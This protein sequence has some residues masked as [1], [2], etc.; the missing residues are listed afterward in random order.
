[1]SRIAFKKALHRSIFFPHL[2]VA[3]IISKHA[4]QRIKQRCGIKSKQKR[5][6]FVKKASKLCISEGQIPNVPE[7]AQFK[8]YMR[9]L[10]RKIKAKGS[11]CSLYL[12]KDFF[13]PISVDGTIITIL[14]NEEY[15]GIYNDIMDLREETK[16]MDY[17]YADEV[18]QQPEEDEEVIIPDEDDDWYEKIDQEIAAETLE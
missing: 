12:Y 18:E 8:D 7:F 3:I 16:G 15:K 4:D 11:Y 5:I 2:K 1:M 10:K 14:T 9:R 17:L 6:A 13:F